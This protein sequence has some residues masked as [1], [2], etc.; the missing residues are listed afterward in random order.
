[1]ADGVVNRPG[2]GAIRVGG[3]RDS[4]FRIV[5]ESG[6]QRAGFREDGGG[7]AVAAGI[8]GVAF[9]AENR[10]AGIADDAGEFPALGIVSVG[11]G[12]AG[13]IGEAV[14]I[15]PGIVAEA[16]GS[17]DGILHDVQVAIER[18]AKRG[19]LAE[20]I[21]NGERALGGIVGIRGGLAGRIG[22]R[23]EVVC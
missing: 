21:R 23:D 15:P 3:Q 6:G 4:V 10:A 17:A 5:E 8:V 7:E 20:R 1:M 13:G 19:G 2:G 12:G 11:G 16:R 14:E 22:F 18:V 9:R